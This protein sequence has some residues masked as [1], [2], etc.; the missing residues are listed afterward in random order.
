MA[1]DEEEHA[2]L[3]CNYFL[4][5]G[6]KAWLLIGNAVPEV[7]CTIVC[8]KTN[9]QMPEECSEC[10]EERILWP[11]FILHANFEKLHSEPKKWGTKNSY[12]VIDLS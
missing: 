6:K 1:G 5:L 4:A 11:D 10:C 9:F 7:S 12:I 2:V 3:L 8:S